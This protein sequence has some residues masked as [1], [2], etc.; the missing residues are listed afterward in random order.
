[1][2]VGTDIVTRYILYKVMKCLLVARLLAFAE[3]PVHGHDEQMGG[4]S[5]G[6]EADAR[7]TRICRETAWVVK[8]LSRRA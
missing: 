6:Q 8:R 3:R 5:R 7:S 2:T 1:M 4:R